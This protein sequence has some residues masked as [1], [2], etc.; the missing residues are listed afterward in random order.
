MGC[1]VAKSKNKEEELIRKNESRQKSNG[2]TNNQDINSGY[3]FIIREA[4]ANNEE[5]AFP[6]RLQSHT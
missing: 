5:S 4:S 1:F 6:S 2:V 3:L